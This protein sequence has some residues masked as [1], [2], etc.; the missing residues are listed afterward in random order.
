M[1]DQ[2]E[3][4]TPKVTFAYAKKK[5]KKCLR[6]LGKKTSDL[7]CLGS[8]CTLKKAFI[9]FFLVSPL[10]LETKLVHMSKISFILQLN[11]LFETALESKVIMN[12]IHIKYIKEALEMCSD[13]YD[14]WK[15]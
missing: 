6:G 5:K 14:F 11:N 9:S 4:V 10:I 2:L 7:S 13:G 15:I 8:T 1:Q 12:I 3:T